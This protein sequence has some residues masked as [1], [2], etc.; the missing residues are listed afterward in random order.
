MKNDFIEKVKLESN[1]RKFVKTDVIYQLINIF[2]G[3]Y[4]KHHYPKKIK[5]TLEVA[6][7]FYKYYNN[8][9]YNMILEAIH[10]N[11]SFVDTQ[12]NKA[13]IKLFGNDADI[14]VLVHEFAH[15]IDINCNPHIIPS[16]YKFI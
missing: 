1:Y 5:N 11:K 6:L 7:E 10:N 3:N 14:F 13:F 15:F 16:E 2:N 8:Q 12:S 9:Y 4:K